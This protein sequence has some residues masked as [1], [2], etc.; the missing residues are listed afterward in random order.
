VN[1]RDIGLVVLGLIGGLVLWALL[2]L[3]VFGSGIAGDET[4][5]ERTETAEAQQGTM[6]ALESSNN[7][8]EAIIT[9]TSTAEPAQ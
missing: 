8:L 2:A 4:Y 6:D 7:T 1:R 9:L 5:G 3:L